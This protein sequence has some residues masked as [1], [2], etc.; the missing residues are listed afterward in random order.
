MRT[1][2]FVLLCVLAF[3]SP[4]YSQTQL[5]KVGNA[6]QFVDDTDY[7]RIKCIIKNKNINE[8]QYCV[9]KNNYAPWSKWNTPFISH[10]R[11]DGDSIHYILSST[12]SAA[13]VI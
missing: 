8:N 3:T 4:Q 5:L 9:V 6:A 13:G 10:E 11:I 2:I 7:P 1:L 12:N